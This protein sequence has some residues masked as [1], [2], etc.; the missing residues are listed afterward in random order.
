M[1]T[2]KYRGSPT[3]A[4]DKQ[5]KLPTKKEPKDGVKTPKALHNQAA[6]TAS[7][8]KTFSTPMVANSW[9][10]FLFQEACTTLEKQ[11]WQLMLQEATTKVKMP[12]QC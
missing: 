1:V 10:T 8:I 4:M 5:H 12:F 9:S 3:H 11:S 2:N 6:A 7:I